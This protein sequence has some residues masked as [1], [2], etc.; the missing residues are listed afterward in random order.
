[1]ACPLFILLSCCASFSLMACSRGSLDGYSQLATSIFS[2]V[3]NL[4]LIIFF[5]T[6]LLRLCREGVHLVLLAHETREE[7]TPLLFLLYLLRLRRWL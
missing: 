3:L 2:E 6:I 1:M 5:F 7:A 4:I